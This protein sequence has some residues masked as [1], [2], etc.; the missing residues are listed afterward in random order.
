[1][2]H[3]CY[4][5]FIYR[6]K[7]EISNLPNQKIIN[8][9]RP[10]AGVYIL[11]NSQEILYIGCSRNVYQRIKNHYWVKKLKNTGEL[12]SIRISYY[13]KFEDAHE[14]EAE[15]INRLKPK[16]NIYRPPRFYKKRIDLEILDFSIFEQEG[17]ID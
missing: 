9:I 7:I 10:M 4:K 1:M 3:L 8:Q 2:F 17:I 13:Q 14:K 5:S 16:Y 11:Y 6:Q 15:F 12:K